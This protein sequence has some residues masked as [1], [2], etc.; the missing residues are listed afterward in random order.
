M[1]GMDGNDVMK[2]GDD[3]D[4]LD[5]GQGDDI[6]DGGAGWDRATY[7]PSALAGVIVDLN[8]VGVAQATGQ[9]NDTLLGIEHLSG[10]RFDDTLTGNAGDNWIWGGSAGS[11]VT[12]NDTL[13]AGGGNDLVQVGTGNHN[14]SGGTGIDTFQTHG[15]GAD[16]TA[17]GV[18]I[19]LA[20]QGMAQDTE[21]GM[22]TLTG[23]EN[24]SGSTFDD[25]LGGNNAD[26]L[27]AG[28]VGS[29]SLAGGDG[30][31]TLY[32]DAGS[33]WTTT[34]PADPGPIVT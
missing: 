8:I 16:I 19:S 5:G 28:D 4:Y 10:T 25:V 2:G 33:S 1:R 29:D 14:A 32:G 3:D 13:T 21:Q 9:G 30:N 24:L 11:G 23:F 6:L 20:L 18:T 34:T 15:N 17:A 31:D 7:A 26:N 22:M 12:G 27:L